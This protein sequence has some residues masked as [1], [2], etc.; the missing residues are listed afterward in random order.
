[1]KQAL[2]CL[3]GSTCLTL[4]LSVGGFSLYRNWKIKRMTSPE[5]RIVSIIQTG[6]EKEALKTAYLAELLHLSVDEPFQLYALDLKKAQSMLLTSPL[7]SD[8]KVKRIPPGTLF[9][10]YTVRKPIALLADYANTAIDQDGFLFPVSPFFSPKQLPEIY[11]G[12]PPFGSSED[13]MERKGGEWL[14][15]LRNR[16]FSLAL[17]V[18]QLL[19]AFPQKEGMQVERIDV[20]N[21]FAPSLGQ[22]EIVLKI[23]DELVLQRSQKEFVCLF[24]K[25][26]RLAP[27]DYRSQLNNFLALRCNMLDDYKRQLASIHQG[28]RFAPR[29]IDLRIPQLAFIDVSKSQ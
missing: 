24:P 14:T 17:E 26:L 21:A 27:K 23:E 7:I 13:S 12:L 4:I 11:L 18:L 25:I 28:G 8:V 16:Y 3:I 20:S 19:E 6:M 15:P 9:I 29:I 2:F 22:R 10:D 5:Y 1:M